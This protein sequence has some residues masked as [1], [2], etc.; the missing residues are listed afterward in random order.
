MLLLAT[1]G[2]RASEVAQ[3]RLEDV[4]WEHDLLHVSRVARRTAQVY[5]LVSTVGNAILHYL[6]GMTLE[7]TARE[8]GLSVSGVRKRLSALRKTLKE[9]EEP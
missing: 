7:E 5:P 2:L 9:L 3:L 1:Y 4:D 8:T 6:D